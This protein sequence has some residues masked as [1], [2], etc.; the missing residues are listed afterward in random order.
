V[1]A[2]FLDCYRR[3]LQDNPIL[4]GDNDELRTRLDVYLLSK[5]AYDLGY[6]LSNRPDWAPVALSGLRELAALRLMNPRPI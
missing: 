1:S 3:Q 2:A 4:P 5:A 6:E